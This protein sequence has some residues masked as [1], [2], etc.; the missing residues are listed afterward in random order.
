MYRKLLPCVAALM[1]LAPA[2]AWARKS[3]AQPTSDSGSAASS[4]TVNDPT[5]LAGQPA[6]DRRV[7]TPFSAR[8]A[9]RATRPFREICRTT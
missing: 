1:R 3:E 4:L 9:R 5:P 8:S 6:Q 2:G 7:L